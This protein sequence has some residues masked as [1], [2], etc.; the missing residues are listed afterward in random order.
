M[1]FTKPNYNNDQEAT[2]SMPVSAP[3]TSV[4]I[5]IVSLQLREG[6]DRGGWGRGGLAEEAG[7]RLGSDGPHVWSVRAGPAEPVGHYNR[8]NVIHTLTN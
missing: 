8:T 5:P 3:C 7:R 4:A 6:S 2:V 1:I